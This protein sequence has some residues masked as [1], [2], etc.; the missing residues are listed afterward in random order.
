MQRTLSLKLLAIGGLTL[1]LLIP[2]SMI[3]E[4]ISARQ[5]RQNEVEQTVAASS[6]GQQVLLGPILAIPYVEKVAT[7]SLDEKNHETIATTDFDRLALF[8]PETLNVEN[9]AN[10]EAK[11]KGLY[12]ALVFENKGS[13]ARAVHR[14]RQ[15]GP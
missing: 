13:L 7:K 10:V 14:A 6:A 8:M 9:V 4:V 11:Y 1:I 2:L 12:K 5:Q 15:P 3:R